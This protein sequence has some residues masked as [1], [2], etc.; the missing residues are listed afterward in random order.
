M[1][2]K[3]CMGLVDSPSETAEEGTRAGE[4]RKDTERG[5]LGGS[6]RENFKNIMYYYKRILYSSAVWCMM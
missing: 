5:K 1:K 3:M 2:T 4:G 6:H